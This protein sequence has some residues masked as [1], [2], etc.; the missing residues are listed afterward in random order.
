MSDAPAEFRLQ[1]DQAKAIAERAGRVLNS[2]AWRHGHLVTTSIAKRDAKTAAETA[3]TAPRDETGPNPRRKAGIALE[4]ISAPKIGPISGP[5]LT[6][7]S[8]L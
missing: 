1:L 2:Y 5:T 8:F 3:L 4:P 7:A 6:Q